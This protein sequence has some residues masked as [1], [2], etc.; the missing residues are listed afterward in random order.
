MTTAEM[1]RKLGNAVRDL[2]GRKLTNGQWFRRPNPSAKVNV[3][4]W[5]WRLQ[6]KGVE[7]RPEQI[8][9]LTTLK[10]V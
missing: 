3:E 5:I 1:T 10:N 9:N 2:H 6:R 8:T 4:R 7:F